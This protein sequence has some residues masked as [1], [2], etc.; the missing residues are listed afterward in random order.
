LNENDIILNKS[1]NNKESEI[2]L[3]SEKDLNSKDIN[4]IDEANKTHK[5]T[6]INSII[7]KELYSNKTM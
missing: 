7:N 3:N 5:E 4:D 6:Q 1:E 2:K